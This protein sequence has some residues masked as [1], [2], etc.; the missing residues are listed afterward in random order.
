M[1]EGLM[2]L[3]DSSVAIKLYKEEEDS[4]IAKEI[5]KFLKEKK[6]KLYAPDI[7]I[8]EIANKLKEIYSD[9]EA[10]E[11]LKS[12][13]KDYMDEII[14]IFRKRKWELGITSYGEADLVLPLNRGLGYE[15]KDLL[16]AIEIA[17]A[18]RISFYDASYIAL[19]KKFN[20][21]LLTADKRHL[22]NKFPGWT[23]SLKEWKDKYCST[24]CT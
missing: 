4:I 15:D 17:K 9:D 21:K 13:I 12:F 8:Y 6:I 10:F 7:I 5:F 23:I 24:N 16:D 14:P 18:H 19:A 11:K 22:L 1:S 20:L 3:V 2:L